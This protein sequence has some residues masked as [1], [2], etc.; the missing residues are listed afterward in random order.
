MAQDTT[1]RQGT[2]PQGLPA[3]G[4]SEPRLR[5]N[6]GAVEYDVSQ[7]LHASPVGISI[8]RVGDGRIVDM[9]AEFLRILGFTREE[10]IGRTS[11]ELNLWTAPDQRET[12][13]REFRAKGYFA[14]RPTVMRRKD[15]SFV[16]VLFSAS[17]LATGDEPH[18]IAWVM[19]I[20]ERLR[21]EEQLRASE[22][23]WRTLAENAP[24]VI[25]TLDRDA[26]VLSVNR[27]MTGRP[28]SEY[29]GKTVFG[30]LHP[31]HRERGR[32]MVEAVLGGGPSATGE[33][34]VVGPDG[35][36]FW[37]Q[38]S[39]APLCAAKPADGVV[40]VA[41]DI[42]R[43]RTMEEALRESEQ[44]FRD[45]V[46]SLGDWVWEVDTA[47]CLTYSSPQIEGLLGYT[48]E[49]M[50]GKS[51]ADSVTPED[52]ARYLAGM[53]ALNQRPEPFRE[54]ELWHLHR[55]GHRV[56]LALSGV[57]VFD[58]AGVLQGFRGVA[59][60]VTE[61]LREEAEVQQARRVESLGV[62]AGGI[63]HD[64]NN[65]L[66][67]IL[68]NAEL[69]LAELAGGGGGPPAHRAD[70][71]GRP[72]RRRADAP[73]ARLRR[74]GPARDPAG[75]PQHH[76]PGDGAAARRLD[77][78]EGGSRPRPRRRAPGGGG[79]PRAAAAAGDE[80]GDQRGR[81]HRRPRGAHR[82]AHRCGRTRGP[83]PTRP[84]AR[85]DRGR[86]AAGVRR[87]RGLR[88]RHRPG[89][90]GEDLRPLLHHEVHRPRARARRRPGDRPAPRRHHRRQLRP[91]RRIDLP[92]LLPRL[93]PPSRRRRRPRRRPR[94]GPARRRAH[95][96][97]AAARS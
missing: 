49:Q 44:R 43:R 82:R 78:E 37:F 28:V 63:A 29:L 62:L 51:P 11:H 52:R 64:F 76:R 56:C 90:A 94:Q 88:P 89:H 91:G 2:S 87:D 70:P 33:F 1:G 73:D 39:I 95:P 97:A 96:G 47:G 84:H 25:I 19:D 15:G 40:I 83:V 27:S 75:G 32:A 80:P 71:V 72:A 65:L 13:V 16:T 5:A 60:D 66:T 61:R 92:R 35:N 26:T 38:V 34:P 31:D 18:T 81:R 50:L 58:A 3:D 57:P 54:R 69:A 59:H 67:A 7:I 85:Q 14:A 21:V 55:D 12:I 8:S 42:N 17:A 36:P 46:R 30:F 74:T 53:E 22:E 24:V 41:T 20:T 93:R 23:R 45:I 48:A 86:P 77:P 4:A 9:N 68:G 6:L 10:V 79:R